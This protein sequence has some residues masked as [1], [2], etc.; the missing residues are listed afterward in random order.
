MSGRLVAQRYAKALVG[1]GIKEGSSESLQRELGAV[2]TLVRSNADLQ[3]L[4]SYPLLAPSKRA[5]AFDAVLA[6]AGASSTLRKFFKVVTLS[7]RLNLIHL[8]I[9]EFNGLMD[10]HMG[11]VEAQ[12]TSAQSLSD[13]QTAALSASLGRRT[14]RTVRMRWHQDPALLGGLKVQLA[15]TVYDASLQG[16]LRQLKAQLLSA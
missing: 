14:G 10:K 13:A 11:V 7:A 16:Q 9:D 12:I 6:Q 15:S 3:R 4:T 2:D 5:E 8:I 1:I